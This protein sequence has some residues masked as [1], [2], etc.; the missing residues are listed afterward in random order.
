MAFKNLG[1]YD[2]GRVGSPSASAPIV[3]NG[4]Q[5]IMDSQAVSSGGAF[6]QSELEKR[7][8]MV[9]EPLTSMT[10]A[11]DIP[12]RVGG[13]WVEYVSAMNVNYGVTGG[14]EDGVVHAAGANGIPMVHAD[15]GKELYKAHIVSVGLRIMWADMQRGNMTGRS[16]E[17]L[18]KD[19]VRL[20]YD[21]HLEA[22]AY[23]GIK[24]YNT[25]GLINSPDVTITNASATGG[26]GSTKW[27]DKTP[28]Q[29]LRDVNDAILMT[30]EAAG[31]DLS[32]VPNHIILPYDQY[33]YVASERVSDIADKTILTFLLEN[34]IA[35]TN[36]SNLFI[37][38]VNW[39]KGA[40]VG[41]TDRMVVY[42]NEERF[43][44]MDELAPLNRAM[45]STNTENVCYD[46]AYMGNVSEVQI[47]YDQVMTYVDGI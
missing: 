10:Y 39:C 13:G 44:A 4:R 14:S 32:A 17:S 19:G 46:T 24:R 26:G 2:A 23:V 38:G 31:N 7:D 40:G 9:R 42:R 20:T 47:F 6:L 11:R 8:P 15:F 29:I 36:G 27:R 1:V 43:I 34:N 45:T 30:W 16:Y 3:T 25:T 41:G 12:I 35:K 18:L 33:N 5:V 37:G 21:K 22:N 28:D